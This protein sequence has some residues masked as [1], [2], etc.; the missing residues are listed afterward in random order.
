MTNTTL[1]DLMGINKQRAYEV[2][3]RVRASFS[4]SETLG[5][6]IAGLMEEFGIDEGNVD[7][8][9]CGWFAGKNAGV[10]E[11]FNVVQKEMEV[12]EKDQ[13]EKKEV[14]SKT[15]GQDGYV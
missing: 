14:E 12:M 15:L 7:V 9:A 6:W 2:A 4:E 13:A 11:L 5:D 8:F 1:S 3:K 10:T